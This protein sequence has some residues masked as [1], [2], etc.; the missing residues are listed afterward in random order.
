MADTTMFA[1]PFCFPELKDMME[2]SRTQEI[3]PDVWLIQGNLGLSF[4]LAPPS[5]NV[6]ILRDDD[7]VVMVD[8]GMHPFY[9][10]VFLEILE[11]FRM[12]G[13][14]TLVL[15]VTQG[16]WDHA[17]N[18]PVILDAGYDRTRFLLPAPE[19][20]VIES[21]HHWLGDFRALEGFFNPYESWAELLIQFEQYAQ[22]REGY[23]DPHYQDAW[24]SIQA[25]TDSPGSRE[26][27]SA[28]KLL[29]ERVLF[30]NFRSLAEQAEVLSLDGREARRFGEVEVRGWQ[31]GRFFI[32]HDGS[33]SPGHISLYDPRHR[34]LLTGDVTIEINPAFFDTSMNRLIKAAR[35]FRQMAEG[36]FVE[37][38]A[39][40][41]RHSG[42][43]Q[44]VMQILGVEA[45]HPGQL[46]DVVRGAHDCTGFL[47]MF[48]DYYVA[49]K[50]E[51]LAAHARLGEATVP[52]IVDALR[53]S[54]RPFVR[55]KMSFPFPSRPELLVARVLDENGATRRTDGE[56]ILFSPPKPWQF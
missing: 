28:V 17:M 55:S 19:V 41:H 14:K 29:G 23:D 16:H 34:L 3:A 1:H 51:T 50:E 22:T 37:M 24:K 35:D 10:P 38:V 47:G 27:R 40:A 2:R 48:E 26:F 13:A 33:H 44:D 42:A 46:M 32:I 43:F 49:L 31:V 30:R 7:L 45:M 9:R 53:Q 15:L 36:G 54:G 52:D 25:L 5:S 12:D 6:Y 39:D 18:N 4:F 8:T 20:P 11:R 56:R 21:I